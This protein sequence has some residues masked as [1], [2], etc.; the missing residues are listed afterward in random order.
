M[1]QGNEQVLIFIIREA[2]ARGLEFG[3]KSGK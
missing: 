1:Q 3:R 2:D